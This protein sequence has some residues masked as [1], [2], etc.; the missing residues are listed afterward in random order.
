MSD[1]AQCLSGTAGNLS[2]VV[3]AIPKAIS[4]TQTEYQ[5][6]MDRQARE[7]VHAIEEMTEKIQAAAQ[8]LAVNPAQN[9]IPSEV[10]EKADRV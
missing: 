3:E 5:E 1:A 2:S 10:R 4:Q 9:D 8:L 6:A 7:Y